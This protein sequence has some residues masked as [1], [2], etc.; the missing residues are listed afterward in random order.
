MIRADPQN[1]VVLCAGCHVFYT[2]RPVEWGDW[3][4]GKFPGRLDYL[5]SL[6]RKGYKPDYE[7]I[8]ADLEKQWADLSK[9]PSLQRKSSP[10]ISQKDTPSNG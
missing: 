9:T 7:S 10:T 6:I 4:E 5:K 3:V 1:S 8:I 2:H